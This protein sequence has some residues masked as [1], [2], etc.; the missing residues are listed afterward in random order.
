[1]EQAD[2]STLF[3]YLSFDIQSDIESVKEV[4]SFKN[5]IPFKTILYFSDGT[6]RMVKS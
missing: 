6:K 4:M 5:K 2:S 3:H 1:M